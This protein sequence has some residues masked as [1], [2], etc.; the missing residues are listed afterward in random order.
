ME[1]A[2]DQRTPMR[3]PS[4]DSRAERP[5]S[6]RMAGR[7][8]RRLLQEQDRTHAEALTGCNGDVHDDLRCSTPMK[9]LPCLSG[10]ETPFAQAPAAG[11]DPLPTDRRKEA[12]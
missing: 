4:D 8:L 10:R 5:T 2:F 9:A 3:A 12:S 11:A 7:G 1:T 6:P